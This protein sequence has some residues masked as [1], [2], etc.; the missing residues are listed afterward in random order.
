MEQINFYEKPVPHLIVDG[1]LE[2][3]LAKICLDECIRLEPHYADAK[4]TQF[5]LLLDDCAECVIEKKFIRDIT[6]DNKVIYYDSYFKDKRRESLILRSLEH[7]VFSD[8]F[9]QL[10]QNLP[11]MFPIIANINSSET[12]LSSYGKCDFYG[13]HPGC[14]KLF[15]SCRIIK[16]PSAIE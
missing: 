1:F 9:M 8:T 2:P 11:Y 4:V 6:R 16:P 14:A 15:V 13:W 12:I 3:R 7:M 10:L 5:E